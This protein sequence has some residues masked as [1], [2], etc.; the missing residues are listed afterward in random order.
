MAY[1]LYLD[2]LVF[3]VAPEKFQTSIKNQNKTINVINEDEINILKNPGLTEFSFELLLPNMKYPFA[4][5]PNNEFQKALY[6]LEKLKSLKANLHPFRLLFTRSLPD[7]TPLFDTDLSVSL[8]D[9]N[10][11]D[12][13]KNGFDIVVS[14][15][16]KQFKD[17]GLKKVTVSEKTQSGSTT[18]T[19]KVA[20]V[21]K[22]RQAPKTP[23]SKNHTVKKGDTLWM[24]AKRYYGDSGK[25]SVIA[26]KN[27]IKNPNRIYPGQVLVL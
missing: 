24:I 3:P 12:D 11:V 9:Y 2:G 16:L 20:T 7:G 14:I 8:E 21:Q 25:Y 10:I 17:Y 23:T 13:A 6:Y 4:E 5:Y 15:K 22:Q 19:K 26:K 18:E 1:K 27:N